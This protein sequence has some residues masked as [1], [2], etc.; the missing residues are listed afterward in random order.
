MAATSTKKT[1]E[2][3]APA[4]APPLTLTNNKE[5]IIRLLQSYN[6]YKY[7]TRCYIDLSNYKMETAHPNLFQDLLK[8]EAIN[9]SGNRLDEINPKIFENLDLLKDLNLGFNNLI[10]LNEKTF[11]N[12]YNLEIINLCHV[13]LISLDGNIF[14]GLI[15]LKEIN[16]S[17]NKLQYLDKNTVNLIQ[18]AYFF[19]KYLII[20]IY[21][22]SWTY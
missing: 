7:L 11:Q 22:V 4:Q 2:Q 20:I 21:L 9:L 3:P 5:D 10:T 19:F 14:Q 8:T 6:K 13:Q 12:I 18:L 1:T 17:L 15:N 16:L